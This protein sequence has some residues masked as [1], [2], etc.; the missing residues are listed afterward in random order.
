MKRFSLQ[1]CILTIILF[2]GSL[3]GQ[4][5]ETRKVKPFSKLIVSPLIDVVLVKGTEE[6]VQIDI[7]GVSPKKLNVKNTGKTLRIFLDRARM[8]TRNEKF[9]DPDDPSVLI[10]RSRYEGARIKAIITYKNLRKI[11]IRGESTFV[12]EDRLGAEKLKIRFMGEV[13]AR[14]ASVDAKLFKLAAYG[15]N[16]ILIKGGAANR[17]VYKIF[18]ES[19]INTAGVSSGVTKISVF[20]DGTVRLAA[21]HVIKLSSFGESRIYY[22]GNPDITKT[23]VLGDTTISPL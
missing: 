5:Q 10:S 19:D 3:Q 17:Q 13:D 2:S 15:E 8:G 16:D 23:L 11:E 4:H 22:V 21:D 14:I 9:V 1:F 7:D 6:S 12:S 20:G 18:G